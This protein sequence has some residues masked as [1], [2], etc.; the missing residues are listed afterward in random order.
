MQEMEAE[1]TGTARR[2]STTTTDG[3]GGWRAE[4]AGVPTFMANHNAWVVHG[5]SV[6]LVA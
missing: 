1:R 6:W 4:L 5:P 2:G 3:K